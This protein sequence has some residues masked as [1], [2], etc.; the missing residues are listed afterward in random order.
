[1][2]KGNPTGN[3]IRSDRYQKKAGWMTKGF[4]LKREFVEEYEKACE[5]AGVNQTAQIRKL[6]QDF[7]DSQKK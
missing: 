4:K 2:P 1:M 5:L 6:M 7:I 3:T